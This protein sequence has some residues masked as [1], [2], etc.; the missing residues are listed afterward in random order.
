[1]G[2]ARPPSSESSVDASTQK[3]E[4]VPLQPLVWGSHTS[5]TSTAP[6]GRAMQKMIAEQLKL[7]DSVIEMFDA[8]DEDDNYQGIGKGSHAEIPRVARVINEQTQK[9]NGRF[10]L[11]FHNGSNE[12][13]NL[14]SLGFALFDQY[15]E[16][17]VLWSFQGRFRSYPRTKV[18]EALNNTT[19]TDVFLSAEYSSNIGQDKFS[20]ILHHEAEEV[21]R[22]MINLGDID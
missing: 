13:I 19:L 8:E 17:K 1:M 4:D 16:S 15:S 3:L 11:I 21:A 5:S 9:L 6:N 14:S 7:S 18:N 22:E 10:L 12:E 20:E 2:W